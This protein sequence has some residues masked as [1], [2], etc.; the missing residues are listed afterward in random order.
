MGRI[1]S[2][3]AWALSWTLLCGAC[4]SPPEPADILAVGFRTPEQAFR[5]F[6]TATRLDNPDLELRCFSLD[7]RARNRISQL[8]WR[9]GRAELYARQPWLRAGIAG[10]EVVDVRSSAGHA[11]LRID[12]A[13]GEYVVELV[14]EDFAEAWAGSERVLDESIDWRTQTGVQPGAGERRWI[15]GRVAIP[16]GVDESA[17]TEQ[18]YGREWKIDDVGPLEA[19]GEAP[20]HR[21]QAPRRRLED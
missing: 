14:R 20:P 6:Q 16:S 10:A 13:G 3:A 5:T 8:T 7:F 2:S 9:E 19:A 1:L 12:T 18:R 17:I 11:R 15:F 4:V 21:A